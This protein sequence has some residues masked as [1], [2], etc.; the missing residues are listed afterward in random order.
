VKLNLACSSSPASPAALDLPDAPPPSGGSG[1]H[2]NGPRRRLRPG[3]STPAAGCRGPGAGISGLRRTWALCLACS[4]RDAKRDARS[5]GISADAGSRM[6]AQRR[7]VSLR[8]VTV[9]SKA[10][11]RGES[12]RGGRGRRWKGRMSIVDSLC[13]Y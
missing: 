6:P 4:R 12:G 8:D 2:W 11:C 3:P 5:S 10:G 1:F 13:T 7:A 9:V